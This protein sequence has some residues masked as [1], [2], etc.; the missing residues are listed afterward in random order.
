M[1]YNKRELAEDI[2]SDSIINKFYSTK[3]ERVQLP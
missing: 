3:H 1:I 2:N